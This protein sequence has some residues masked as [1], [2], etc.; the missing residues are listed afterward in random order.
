MPW[1]G[2]QQ[3]PLPAQKKCISMIV[4]VTFASN[5]FTKALL[6]PPASFWMLKSCR[7]LLPLSQSNYE[8]TKKAS[9]KEK[10]T[11]HFSSHIP[12]CKRWIHA[13]LDLSR[14]AS[15]PWLSL[16]SEDQRCISRSLN[17]GHSTSVSSER[18]L[19]SCTA[20]NLMSLWFENLFVLYIRVHL[21]L[22]WN[23]LRCLLP[24]GNQSLRKMRQLPEFWN[25][26][27]IQCQM[28]MLFVCLHTW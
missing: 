26:H 22:R 27:Q 11:N 14:T 6:D 4:F 10:L 17:R 2:M 20:Q 15:P 9:K 7:T 5:V 12:E 3:V 13:F 28:L 18:S 1:N 23:S 25:H 19:L 21:G 24:I 16:Q 8:K